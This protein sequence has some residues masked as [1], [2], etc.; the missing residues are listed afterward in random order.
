[1]GIIVLIA[2]AAV[3]TAGSIATLT[4]VLR[5][6]YRATPTRKELLPRP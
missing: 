5:D 1:M 2:I 3:V 4:Q 6:G